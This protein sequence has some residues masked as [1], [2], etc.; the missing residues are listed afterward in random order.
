M[1]RPASGG[2]N[3]S[4]SNRP[5]VAANPN[6]SVGPG[7]QRAGRSVH[8][9]NS[10]DGERPPISEFVAIQIKKTFNETY[11]LHTTRP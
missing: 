4:G 1:S 2:V 10:Q 3:G 11:D 7:S 6:Q 8:S 9:A 5:G